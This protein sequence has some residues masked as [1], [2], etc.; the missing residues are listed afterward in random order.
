MNT[1][2]PCPHCA[3]DRCHLIELDDQPGDAHAVTCDEC[4]TRGP[5]DM[6]DDMA[7][8]KWNLRYGHETPAKRIDEWQ[9]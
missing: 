8:F 3:H 6:T 9:H 4:G 2:R 1:I 7:V 5:A